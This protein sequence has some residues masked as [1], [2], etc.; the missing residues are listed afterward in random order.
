M[1]QIELLY[2]KLCTL[3][4]TLILKKFKNIEKNL[5]KKIAN[6]QKK[7]H[8]S[9]LFEDISNRV[10]FRRLKMGDPFDID[11]IFKKNDPYLIK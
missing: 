11:D 9:S 5:L 4:H 3:T 1:G 6:L 2:E 10:K 7:L 8:G